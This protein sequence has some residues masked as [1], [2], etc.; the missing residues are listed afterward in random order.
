MAR[1]Q[2]HEEHV[3]HEAWA[4][5]YADLLVLLLAFFVVMY[6]ISAVNEGKFRVL[7]VSLTDAFSGQ[8]RSPVPIQAGELGA[9]TDS[10]IRHDHSGG[11]DPSPIALPGSPP[12]GPADADDAE[13]EA[14]ARAE[15]EAIM[16]QIAAEVE[17]ALR[18]L[19]DEGVISIDRSALWLKIEINTNILFAS[20]S[21]RVQ[22]R[23][24]PVLRDIARILAR[25]TN[26]IEV[27]GFT[28]TVPINTA[29]FPS[30]WELS[31][32][33][34]ASVVHLFMKYDVAPMRMAA[35]G[36]GE[37]R[38]FADNSTAE[39]RA[40]NR[41]VV[42]VVLADRDARRISEQLAVPVSRREAEPAPGP[43]LLQRWGE[44]P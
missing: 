29:Q 34:A 8:P 15:S 36:Y 11:L 31:A 27:E 10:I 25:F 6:S 38:P 17:E 40:R 19:M 5:P 32:G 16:E 20:G 1:K 3:N 7:S 2:K 23:A 4:I 42:I 39:G 21:A 43:D 22:E 28:D 44:A 18:P 26:P 9:T 13:A 35:I 14:D 33:R 24:V 12:Q 37:H 30:N 41:R